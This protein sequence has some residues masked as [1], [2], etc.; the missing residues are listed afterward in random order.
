M[1]IHNSTAFPIITASKASL[2]NRKPIYGVGINDADY[3]VTPTINGKQIKCPYYKAWKSMFVRC[4]SMNCQEKQPTYIGCRVSS[5][6][7]LFSSFKKWMEL[8][9]WK[10]K[11][12]DKDVMFPGNKIYGPSNCVF[13]SRKIN[14]LLNDCAAAKGAFPIGTSY[15]K[16]T[17]K[18]TARICKN[19]NS[20]PLGYF[21][22]IE[23]ASA[24][25]REAKRLHILTI[26]CCEPDIRVKQGLY[27]HSL[28]FAQ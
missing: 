25:Y 8:Q 23:E 24:T 27:R 2:A 6:W 26:A 15:H 5:K 18:Y 12:L 1:N 3:V 16:G 10:G 14:A 7:F 22:K 19:G 13:V 4:Y 9:D 28:R 21:D 17:G 11:E 20:T